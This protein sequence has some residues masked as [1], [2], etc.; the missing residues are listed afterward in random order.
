MVILSSF[1]FW[2]SFEHVTRAISAFRDIS[3]S[4]K[5]SKLLVI[6]SKTLSELLTDK[7]LCKVVG[8]TTSSLEYSD[9]L[10]KWLA[11]KTI[12]IKKFKI[13]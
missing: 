7:Y 10:R 4:R 3:S 13:K 5:S 12:K 9:C 1:I 11:T 2:A 8:G 6:L